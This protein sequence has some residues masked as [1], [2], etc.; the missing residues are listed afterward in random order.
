M[1]SRLSRDL[2]LKFRMFSGRLNQARSRFWGH[3]D[4]AEL[5]PDLIFRM[6]CEARS[7]VSLLRT[8]IDRLKALSGS[9]PLASRLLPY[10]AGLAH[11]ET[12]HDDWLL[13]AQEA[14]GVSRD[15]AWHR[16]PPATTA[17]MVGSQYYW[18]LHHH[19][20]ALLGFIKAVEREPPTRA[21]ID[22]LRRRTGLPK[23]AFTYQLGHVGV[24]TKHNADLDRVLDEL[25]FSEAHRSLMGVSLLNT[26]H[27]LA[28][29]LEEMVTLHESS[30]VSP[31]P[32]ARRKRTLRTIREVGAKVG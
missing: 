7:T 5:F 31:S 12:G 9:D 15:E 14:V 25:P 13:Q 29:G 17:A 4:I 21:D 10:L 30:R 1:A 27:F 23:G 32:T 19:P 22:A 8:A 11:E 18:I 2:E 28:L 3:P 24:E 16:H 6:H 26:I 20:V